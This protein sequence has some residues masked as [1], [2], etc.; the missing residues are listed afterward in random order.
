MICIYLNFEFQSHTYVICLYNEDL[1][2]G[3]DNLGERNVKFNLRLNY[4]TRLDSHADVS[5]A[6]N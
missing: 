5:S 3:R 1:L 6:A 2:S 4:M